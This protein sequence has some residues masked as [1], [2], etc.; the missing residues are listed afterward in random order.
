MKR[1]TKHLLSVFAATIAATML[2]SCA[3]KEAPV[4]F[5][6]EE[7]PS[8]G[9]P[10]YATF[11]FSVDG[12]TKAPLAGDA[13]EKD[14]IKSIRLMI[15]KRLSN[16]TGSCEIDT[17]IMTNDSESAA[18]SLESGWKYILVI[19]NDYS[20]SWRIPNQKGNALSKLLEER[21]AASGGKLA[22]H[23]INFGEP[24]LSA[25]TAE[26]LTSLDYSSIATPDMIFSNAQAALP[27]SA[28]AEWPN[29]FE[30]LPD[31]TL[32]QS[33]ADTATERSNHFR[34]VL[35]RTVAKV[36]IYTTSYSTGTGQ[37]HEDGALSD[38]YWGVRN[39]SRAISIF[40]LVDGSG[41][42][43]PPFL[44]VLDGLDDT[45]WSIY[46]PY[47]WAGDESGAEINIPLGNSV[48]SNYYVPENLYDKAGNS[49]Y[50]VVKANFKPNVVVTGFTVDE[51]SHKITGTSYKNIDKG[52]TYY[53]VNYDYPPET[54]EAANLTI[55]ESA[56]N[57]QL[58]K[59]ATF[60]TK[61]IARRLIY[62]LEQGTA[63]GYQADY[64]PI[65]LK[66]ETYEGGTC[67]YR[68]DIADNKDGGLLRNKQYR[69][70]ITN[71]RGIGLPRL[72]LLDDFKTTPE[73]G[74]AG[75]H[76]TATVEIL[77]WVI[78]DVEL[79]K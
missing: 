49:T 59:K 70:R 31:I 25:G 35:Q 23:D 24:A 43:Q 78:V 29:L 46:N 11:S 74:P 32:A 57:G 36:G 6:E 8:A 65:R 19:A 61:D 17:T 77:P 15:Y 13:A 16:S 27:T 44:N 69:G 48:S 64:K 18:L 14:S 38:T 5:E 22:L 34:M 3:V 76:A 9:V 53:S 60:P 63:V 71:F 56:F 62:F 75:T 28:T 45:D 4:A 20:K 40:K 30:I 26:P 41:K 73:G 37:R 33:Q 47:W 55:D 79:K 52:V 54:E 58:H 68:F 2:S 1:M 7:T 12:V 21:T 10:S 39:Q 42:V 67:Y 66:I 51:A 50:I 72:S